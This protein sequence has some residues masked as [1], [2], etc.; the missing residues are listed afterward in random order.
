MLKSKEEMS[1]FAEIVLNGRIPYFIGLYFGAPAPNRCETPLFR[2]QGI[3]KRYKI[4]SCI[5]LFDCGDRIWTCLAHLEIWSS[6]FPLCVQSAEL[7]ISRLHH[8][9]SSATGSGRCC[10]PGNPSGAGHKKKIQDFFLYL[11]FRL[12]RQDL[13]LRPPGYEPDELPD[14]STPRQYK[15]GGEGFEPSKLSQQIYSLPPLAARESTHS[16]VVIF[17]LW[18]SVS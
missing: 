18:D 3:K 6:A 17:C 15:M 14:C 8:L 1:C 9:P 2:A 11:S 7:S 10:S 4:F 5:F 16:S 12:R 13:N